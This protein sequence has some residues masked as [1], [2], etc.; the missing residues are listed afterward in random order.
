MCIR[1][2]NKCIPTYRKV[3]LRTSIYVIS[4]FDASFD[5]TDS[6]IMFFYENASI[7]GNAFMWML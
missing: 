7:T 3:R 5:L 6:I 1:D 2:R 4:W